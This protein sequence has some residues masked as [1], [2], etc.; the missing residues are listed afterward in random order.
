MLFR[1]ARRMMP[2]VAAA[3]V[4]ATAAAKTVGSDDGVEWA[5]PSP[6]HAGVDSG[7][8]FRQE[9][10]FR[11]RREEWDLTAL[12]EVWTESDG[13]ETWPWEDVFLGLAVAHTAADLLVVHAGRE[14]FALGSASSLHKHSLAIAP[15]TWRTAVRSVLLSGKIPRPQRLPSLRR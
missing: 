14:V 7:A 4:G 9:R 15:S 1:L 3:T 13:E 2:P 6:Y 5:W 12:L 8:R 11:R 10:R